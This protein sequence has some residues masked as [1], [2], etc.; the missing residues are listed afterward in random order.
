MIKQKIKPERIDIAIKIAKIA[1][2]I[3]IKIAKNIVTIVIAVVIWRLIPDPVWRYLFFLR[4][5]IFW[6]LLLFFLPLVATLLLPNILKNLFVLRGLGQLISVIVSANMAVLG[7]I[8]N[9]SMILKN[10]PERFQG[11]LL[12]CLA[13][14][15]KCLYLVAIALSLWIWGNCYCLSKEEITKNKPNQKEVITENQLKLAVIIAPVLSLVLLFV[16]IQTKEWI[17]NK[18]ASNEL[19]IDF[20]NCIT[21]NKPNGYIGTEKQQL[22]EGHLGSFAFFIVALILYVF[23]GLIFQ[24][25]AKPD[26]KEAP[27]LMY[28]MLIIMMI[29]PLSGSLTF[30]FDYYRFPIFLPFVVFVA[31]M[32][33]LFRVNHFFEL[34][35]DNGEKPSLDDLKKAIDK[36][37]EH[38]G[39][40]EK[41]LV[42]VCAS[43]GGIQA[44]GWTVQVL[45]GLQEELGDSFTKAIGIISSVSGGSVGT[46]YYLDRFN[47]EGTLEP[48][49]ADKSSIFRSATQDS[50]DAVG[51]GLA[52]P[53]LWRII[54]LPSLAPKM[55]DRGT[56]LETDWQGELEYPKKKTTLADWRE[57]IFKGQ[58]PIPIFNATLVEDGRRFLISPM[59]FCECNNKNYTVD[60]NNLY[61]KSDMNIVTAARL[62]A[63]FSYISPISRNSVDQK[64]N[65]H[66][67][68]GGYFDNSGMVTMVEWLNE[69]LE[70]NKG[71]KIK[72]VLLLQINAFPEE[73][74]SE[75][76]N[77][78]GG[79][80]Q[81]IIGPFLTL[82]SVR[83]TTQLSRT[84][85]EVELLKEKFKNE[86][87]IEHFPI[88]F[89]CAKEFE[90]FKKSHS[91]DEVKKKRKP[92]ALFNKNKENK[93]DIALF[94]KKG[95]YK[96]PLSWKLTKKE[97]S[98]IKDGWK[99]LQNSQRKKLK[100]LWEDWGF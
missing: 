96:P 69:W 3:A 60:F 62:S 58:I 97:K 7:V 14:S 9:A 19:L 56:A 18:F 100:K 47:S 44:A 28:V 36:R 1:I 82:F 68:D 85:T 43:G 21:N 57:Q 51:W 84:Y 24:P 95:E 34:K 87:V 30:Y 75:P 64:P 26:Q 37:L 88:S 6:G 42:V 20:V 2:K 48:D 66:I 80:L 8:L 35:D 67:A 70:P 40:D 79:W 15:D 59:T 33:S 10:A 90:E 93:P 74:I 71:L 50:L 55:C 4:A 27:A 73:P 23:I 91:A 29:A 38:Q 45:T 11:D 83:N 31:L 65:Y 63:S 61:P 32:Y 76:I 13:I 78:D 94:N 86:V 53:D 89:P 46:M 92:L 16:V 77:G 41:T 22:L 54:G 17:F 98:A 39:N 72:R 81:A 5:P 25:Q 49:Q 52:Y 99:I 12:P